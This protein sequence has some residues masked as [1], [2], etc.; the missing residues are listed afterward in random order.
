MRRRGRDGAERLLALATAGLPARRA[1]WGAAMRAELASIDD[2][3]ARL[4]FARGASAA[5]FSEGF[6]IRIVLASGA[7]V[8]VAG[9]ALTASR[10]QLQDGG[11]G[12]LAVTVPAPAVALLA[13]A[14]LAA[15]AT[16]SFRFGMETGM[17]AL[18]GSLAAVFCVLAVEGQ[19]WMQRFGVF[20]LDGDPP[21]HPVGAADVVLDL[22]STGMWVGHLVF[23][24]PW[25]VIGAALG[26]RLGARRNPAEAAIR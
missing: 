17:L 13:V 1:E 16:R 18:A 9:M 26:A 24:F 15:R 3:N 7:A 21:R 19:V 8:I 4:R 25:T 12:V 23:W 10:V 20:M 14:F 22:F 5:A 6:G 2:T 11:P